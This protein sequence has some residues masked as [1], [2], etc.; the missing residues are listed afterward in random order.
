MA[1]MLLQGG[2]KL[3]LTT[4]ERLYAA[5]LVCAIA[6]ISRRT[7][8]RTLP[9]FPRRHAPRSLLV[10]CAAAAALTLAAPARATGPTAG[11][12]P[13]VVSLAAIGLIVPYGNDMFMLGIM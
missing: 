4:L 3:T 10:P 12:G 6:T 2:M 11:T 8:M 9:I 1:P 13:A 7:L 5:G